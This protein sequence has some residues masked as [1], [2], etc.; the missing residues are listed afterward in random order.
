[1]NKCKHGVNT[2]KPVQSVGKWEQARHKLCNGFFVISQ[3]KEGGGELFFGKKY[4]RA[5]HCNTNSK[6]IQNSSFD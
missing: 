5:Y 4:Q 1:M 6:Q 2:L 3:E